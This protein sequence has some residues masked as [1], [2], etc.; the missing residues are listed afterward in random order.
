MYKFKE[1]DSKPKLLVY[2]IS[3]NEKR[4]LMFSLY[5]SDY[6]E[7][8]LLTCFTGDE[9]LLNSIQPAKVLPAKF[10]F[11]KKIGLAFSLKF[12]K[13]I[14]EYLPAFVMTIETHS[15][16]SYQSIKLSKRF[17]YKPV[18]FS[19][20][21]VM[22]IPKYYFQDYIQ[23][24]VLRNSMYFLAGTIDTKNYLI[25][26]GADL[27]K[28]FIN[29]ESGYDERIFTDS[30]NDFRMDWGFDTD[31]KIVL[32]A[33]RLIK[34]KG[35]N[36]ILEAAKKVEL[37]HSKLKFVF[38]GKGDLLNRIKLS[39]SKNVYYKGLYDFT[40][41]GKVLRTCDIFI[42][43]SISTKY[44]IE[45]FGYSV[46]EAQACM[47][48]VIVS[49]SGNLSRFVKD[50]INGSIINEK[51]ENSLVEKIVLWYDKI[52]INTTMD[53]NSLLKFSG[54]SIAFNY[55]RI[56]INNDFSLLNNWF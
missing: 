44:W 53:K 52:K 25:K 32:Y 1:K 21:N 42:Y 48:P 43:P 37:V 45:Q 23:R 4:N 15:L 34:E 55:K 38:I 13:Y 14:K 30:G 22:S 18:V 35:I 17:N 26:K 40:E 11:K 36:M 7:V 28:I 8:I 10:W 39:D 5:L 27:R 9:E 56:L 19:W 24:K 31:D 20:Q 33:G 47:K 50:G 3:W 51:D 54:R 41:M 6:F 49:N 16:S 46:I 2:A 29:P 12:K